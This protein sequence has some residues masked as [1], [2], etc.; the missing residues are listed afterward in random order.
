M[1][2][3]SPTGPARMRTSDTEREQAA[4]ILRAAMSE[5]R[6]TLEEGEERL[7]AVYAAKFRDEL[8]PLTADLPN[9][10]RDAL[11]RT[12]QA[13]AATRRELRGATFFVAFVAVVLTGVW[14]VSGAHFFWPAIPLTFMVLGLMRRWGYATH[15]EWHAHRHSF[16][17]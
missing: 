13:R 6:L 16:G 14:F 12:P 5:G 2:A 7:G 1:T 11:A 15:P 8:A 10:G 9:G 3:T 4:T 17:K